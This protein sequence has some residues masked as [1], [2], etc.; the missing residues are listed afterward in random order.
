M[1]SDITC[2]D[3]ALQPVPSLGL[4]LP[5]LLTWLPDLHLAFCLPTWLQL[6]NL[7]LQQIFGSPA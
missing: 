1:G 6:R 3:P 7:L 4:G 2:A 5:R